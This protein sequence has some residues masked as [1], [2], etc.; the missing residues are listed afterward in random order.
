MYGALNL[1]LTVCNFPVRENRFVGDGGQAPVCIS[2][3]C[4]SEDLD[5]K[6]S[7]LSDNTGWGDLINAEFA[8]TMAF[9]FEEVISTG[10]RIR[11]E[12]LEFMAILGEKE[13]HRIR[14][15]RIFTTGRAP[16]EYSR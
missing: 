8:G 7:F 15:E 11:A 2:S 4:V 1:G 9:Y 5:R 3:G 6:T 12:I 10:E 13:R 16:G 14:L